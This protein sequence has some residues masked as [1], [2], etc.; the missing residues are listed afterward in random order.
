M[1]ADEHPLDASYGPGTAQALR[2]F[3]HHCDLAG[4]IVDRGKDAYDTDITLRLAAEA[5]IVRLGESVA[6]LPE[7]FGN[8]HADV[9]WAAIRGTRNRV[10]HEYQLTDPEVIWAALATRTPQH[11]AFVVDLLGDIG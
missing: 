9:P 5:V 4:H 10:G 3:V 1:D 7:R 11:R 8:D 2:D 6:R